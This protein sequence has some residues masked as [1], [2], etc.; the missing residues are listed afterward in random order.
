MLFQKLLAT[1]PPE[2]HASLT[3]RYEV[4]RAD[5]LA[6]IENAH[7]Y[8]YL[9]LVNRFGYDR[10]K[11][12]TQEQSTTA[13]F[14]EVERLAKL[15]LVFEEMGLPSF[16]DGVSFIHNQA[17]DITPSG[18]VKEQIAAFW[19]ERTQGTLHH[20]TY[21]FTGDGYFEDPWWRKSDDVLAFNPRVPRRGFLF[22]YAGLHDAAAEYL[23]PLLE[24][25][26]QMAHYVVR[27]LWSKT[28]GIAIEASRLR[29]VLRALP[30][31]PEC[32]G[33]IAE[34]GLPWW[35]QR[36]LEGLFLPRNAF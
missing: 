18:P 21:R 28:N 3:S 9:R 36:W 10:R 6:E 19:K 14:S 2:R 32:A 22:G 26:P 29:E 5:T 4:L 1:F 35:E 34:A 12:E 8:D 20:H 27:N 25:S 15:R 11:L 7:Q 13:A 31:S 16:W 17:K 24:I 33:E 23:S 30:K